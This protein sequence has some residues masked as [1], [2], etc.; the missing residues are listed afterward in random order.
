MQCGR[1]LMRLSRA[2][3]LPAASATAA[4]RNALFLRV[5]SGGSVSSGGRRTRKERVSIRSTVVSR[6]D[7]VQ[8][9]E[10]GG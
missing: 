6:S 5:I 7:T 2:T 4:D 1:N 3:V 9:S 10:Y 8:G